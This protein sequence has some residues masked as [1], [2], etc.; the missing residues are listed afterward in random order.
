[1]TRS[2]RI[3]LA[4]RNWRKAASAA[5]AYSA[6]R[7]AWNVRIQLALD[8]AECAAANRLA[9]LINASAR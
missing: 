8:N 6:A 5:R 2:I 3:T 9:R 7:G 1:M 4:R